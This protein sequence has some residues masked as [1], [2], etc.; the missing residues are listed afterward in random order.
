[1]NTFL[2]RALELKE[3]TIAHRRFLHQHAEIR[4]DLPITAG[5]VKEQL[6]KVGIE[7]VEICK[8]GISSEAWPLVGASR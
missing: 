5:Y 2:K 8:S 7:P 3:E 4:D 1:M 6:L